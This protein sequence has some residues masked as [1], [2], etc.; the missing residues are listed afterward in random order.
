MRTGLGIDYSYVELDEGSHPPSL[1]F[2]MQDTFLNVWELEGVSR[3]AGLLNFALTK[4]RLA[5]SMALIVLDF[6][7]PWA[8]PRCL[9]KWLAVLQVSGLHDIP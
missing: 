3:H 1:N 4:E 7:Q 5:H 8:L 9:L 2:N 6:L